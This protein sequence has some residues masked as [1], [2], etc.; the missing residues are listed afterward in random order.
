M[1]FVARVEGG[2]DRGP[3]FDIMLEYRYPLTME[4]R[5]LLDMGVLPPNATPA[6]APNQIKYAIILKQLSLP[7]HLQTPKPPA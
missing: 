7:H 6:L 3:R 5:L 4:T 1:A 2:I